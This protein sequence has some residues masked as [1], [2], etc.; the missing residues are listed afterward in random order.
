MLKYA[1][2]GLSSL[3]LVH[4][5]HFDQKNC[6]PQTFALGVREGGLPRP[7]QEHRRECRGR[8]LIFSSAFHEP[9]SGRALGE[10]LVGM[11]NSKSLDG[12]I[13]MPL[14]VNVILVV[15]IGY[16]KLTPIQN[17]DVP[18]TDKSHHLIAFAARALPLSFSRLRLAPWV[19]VAA[20][21]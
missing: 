3:H 20:A 17:P 9:V 18:G 12:P 4:H 11:S 15:L 16:F 21:V 5:Q 8:P 13:A 10:P 2:E 7:Y 1:R 14:A 6:P 19:V